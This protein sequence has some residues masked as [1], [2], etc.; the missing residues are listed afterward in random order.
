MGKLVFRK[1]IYDVLVFFLIL[2]ISLT[3]IVWVIQAV[4]Y[5]DFVSEDGHSFFVYFQ[6]VILIL[7]KIFGKLVIF[8]FFVSIFYVLISYEESNEILIYWSYGISKFQFINVIFKF[9]LI[10][11][12]FQ[13]LFNF[14]VIPK[15][16]DM[17]RSNI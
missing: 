6:Y 11:M 9:S 2:S 13:I 12:V 17:A 8:S 15:T 16:Q 14:F 1:F 4:N 5:L 3:L 10:I 7:P